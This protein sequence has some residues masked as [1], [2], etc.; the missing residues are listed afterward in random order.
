LKRL[1][2]ILVG[3]IDG[4]GSWALLAAQQDKAERSCEEKGEDGKAKDDRSS[5]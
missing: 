4:N 1:D 3:N 5:H 2:C